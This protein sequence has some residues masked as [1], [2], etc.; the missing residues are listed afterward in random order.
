MSFFK[1]NPKNKIFLGLMAILLPLNYLNF[2]ANANLN[3]NANPDAKANVNFNGG[4]SDTGNFITFSEKSS[5]LQN[6]LSQQLKEDISDLN[7]NNGENNITSSF[8]YQKCDIKLQLSRNSKGVYI[9]ATDAKTR[10][11]CQRNFLKNIMPQVVSP[12]IATKILNNKKEFQE[13]ETDI[14]YSNTQIK[15][16]TFSFMLFECEETSTNCVNEVLHAKK[17]IQK[18]QIDNPEAIYIPVYEKN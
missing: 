12:E 8:K 1:F 5:H 17:Q 4:K 6:F 9:K 2:N 10:I 13:D 16:K 15:Q 3:V 7:W 14:F 11:A 18:K